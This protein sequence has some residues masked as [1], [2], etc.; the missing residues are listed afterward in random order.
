MSGYSVKMK[1]NDVASVLKLDFCMFLITQIH[2]IRKDITFRKGLTDMCLKEW[3]FS[4]HY[5]DSDKKAHKG[6]RL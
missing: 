6:A 3:I 5:P 1:F 4:K 2:F